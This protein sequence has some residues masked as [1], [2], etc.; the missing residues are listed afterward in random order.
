AI[1]AEASLDA[2]TGSVDRDYVIAGGQIRLTSGLVSDLGTLLTDPNGIVASVDDAVNS[3]VGSDGLLAN[4]LA[5]L[6][7]A[8][9]P[10][11]GNDAVLISINVD[12]QEALNQIIN[13]P[14]ENEDGSVS[15]NL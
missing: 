8:L 13:T 2:A 11:L 12:I 7:A 9:S 14:L 1:A 3:L 10:L 6:N 15:V 4:V 5:G